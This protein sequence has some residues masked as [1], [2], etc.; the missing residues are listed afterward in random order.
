VQRPA[1]L[2]S[3]WHAVCCG[4]ELWAPDRVAPRAGHC[5]HLLGSCGDADG[6]L[7]QLASP[8]QEVRTTC[9]DE[10]MQSGVHRG[11][12]VAAHSLTAGPQCSRHH[13]SPTRGAQAHWPLLP[14]PPNG[15]ACT[16]QGMLWRRHR[17]LQCSSVRVPPTSNS[18]VVWALTCTAPDHKLDLSDC[19]CVAAASWRPS[20]C[21]PHRDGM[22]TRVCGS[23]NHGRD[24]R[25]RR[26]WLQQGAGVLRA[27]CWRRVCGEAPAAVLLAGACA[28]HGG[29]GSCLISW[30]QRELSQVAACA[31]AGLLGAG[32]W[33]MGCQ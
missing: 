11:L 21:R 27:R 29:I 1:L 12:Y 3:A 9:R 10:A 23:C 14:A 28:G 4:C 26:L 16:A 20:R 8:H 31:T 33:S 15:H 30:R 18:I 25:C 7:A 32:A 17:R 5:E 24:D 19:G 2:S 22:I 6:Q 13:A